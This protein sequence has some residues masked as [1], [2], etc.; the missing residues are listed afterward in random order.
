MGQKKRVLITNDDGI[1]AAGLQ[2]LYEALKEDYDV[3]IV[4]PQLEQSAVSLSI[5]IRHPLRL[6]PFKGYPGAEAYA[7]NGTPADC[8]KLALHALFDGPP[9]L[10]VSGIN[11][12]S[13]AGRNVLYS[14]TIGGVIEGTLRG[15]P[16]IAFSCLAFHH[17]IYEPFSAYVKQITECVFHS[18]L[19]FGTLLNVNFPETDSPRGLKYA[20]QG[21]Q[22]WLENPEMRH[23]PA[24]GHTYYWLG[25]KCAE[26]D[27]APD[28]DISLLYQG[29]V[30]AV[31]LQVSDLTDTAYLSGLN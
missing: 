11:R 23:H 8:V 2:H 28:S 4:A 20:R 24:E 3:Y 16:G 15:I 22:Y 27:E 14:G 9:D 21:R 7:V 5:T 12:G 25:G 6:M 26:F 13:N 29:Y 10:I 1:Q 18:S 31:P 30:T 19:P 17:T